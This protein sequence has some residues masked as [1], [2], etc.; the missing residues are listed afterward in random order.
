MHTFTHRQRRCDGVAVALHQARNLL[1]VCGLLDSGGEAGGRS[2]AVQ[3][4]KRTNGRTVSDDNER[5]EK[6]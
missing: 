6:E 1:L 3:K 4:I 2:V 5:E